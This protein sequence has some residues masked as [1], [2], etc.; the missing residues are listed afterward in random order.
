MGDLKCHD[1][2]AA[3]YISY[4][5]FALGIVG[6]AL[7]ILS[8]FVWRRCD[9]KTAAHIYLKALAVADSIA[10][11][12]DAF[13]DGLDCFRGNKIFDFNR[14]ICVFEAAFDFLS[15]YA[16]YWLIA[17]IV[18]DRCIQVM[19]PHT[20][21]N[22]FN[23]PRV[24][25]TV[26]TITM[27]TMYLP[28]FLIASGVNFKTAE[29]GTHGLD[30]ERDC[31]IAPDAYY[32]FLLYGSSIL[33][34]GLSFLI[35]IVSTCIL[36]CQ[37]RAQDKTYRLTSVRTV[38][39]GTSCA[40][41]NPAKHLTAPATGSGG[42]T[43]NVNPPIRG[44]T[45]SM[46]TQKFNEQLIEL[47]NLA[48]CIAVIFVVLCGTAQGLSIYSHLT[49][50]DKPLDTRHIISDALD[51]FLNVCNSSINFFL[52]CFSN[53][54]FKLEVKSIVQKWKEN[55]RKICCC[56]CRKNE[57][58]PLPGIEQQ[59]EENDAQQDISEF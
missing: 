21:K 29:N 24:A 57:V 37:I 26:I 41:S 30:I 44:R 20:Y 36:F 48:V 15:T 43:S 33:G 19:K 14:H 27:L 42:R 18:V 34:A 10:I 51:E 8:F 12:S 4:V 38:R 47:R 16:T 45:L 46:A 50:G 54:K 17:V 1:V 49:V 11:I 23:K 40:G 31:G 5:T 13:I 3:L 35:V 28:S 56:C 55:L 59:D 39:P 22:V 2:P 9:R 58:E 53:S 7:N 52:Y 6:L 25:W 32:N